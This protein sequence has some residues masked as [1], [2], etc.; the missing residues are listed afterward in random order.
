[1]F[2]CLPLDGPHREG[3]LLAGLRTYLR[4][5]DVAQANRGKAIK[6]AKLGKSI[7]R[8]TSGAPL[9]AAREFRHVKY[10]ET[11]PYYPRARVRAAIPVNAAKF[12]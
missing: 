1:M 8:V 5:L 3:G 7:T 11:F 6:G 12:R 4:A 10:P 2:G 9:Q